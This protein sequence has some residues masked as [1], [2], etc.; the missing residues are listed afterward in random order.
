MKIYGP[1][2]KELMTI[3]AIERESSELIMRGKIF[4]TMPLTARLQPRNCA[5]GCA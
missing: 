5:T 3:T 2:G 1:D 4:G